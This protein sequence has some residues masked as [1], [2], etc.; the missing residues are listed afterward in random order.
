MSDT[1][2]VARDWSAVARAWDAHVEDVDDHSVAATAALF[3]RVAVQLGD[4]VLELA[5]GPGSLGAAWSQLV[6]P[7]G[8]VVLSDLAPGMVEVARRRNAALAN[9]DVAVLDASAIDRADASFDVVAARMGLMFTPDPSI[10]FAEIH[11]VLAPGGRLGALTWA[12]IEHNPWMTCVGMAAMMNGLVSGGPPVG[13]GSIFSLGDTGELEA[14]VK[15]AGFVDVTVEEI[16]LTFRAD[17]IDTHV[18]RVS[19]LAGPLATILQGA[20]AD[21][22]AAVRRTAAVLA[23]QYVGDGGLEIPGRALLVCGRRSDT[24]RPR[25]TE[26]GLPRA[27]VTCGGCQRDRGPYHRNAHERNGG[28]TGQ[29][30]GP[31]H[32]AAEE[33]GEAEQDEPAAD[34]AGN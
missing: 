25:T 20:S 27:G 5:A 8:T 19:S 13:P 11:R 16:A 30:S 3:D 32:Q 1:S 15:G 9:V 33:Q 34:H 18:T 26:H 31:T 17:D 4:R 29:D 14:L 2:Q 21:K 23:A 22:Q 24:A 6:G 7:T 28:T 10:A 12:G